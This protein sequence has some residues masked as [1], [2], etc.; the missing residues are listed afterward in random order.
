MKKIV[1]ST[2]MFLSVIAGA[3][4]PIASGSASTYGQ[5][6]WIAVKASTTVSPGI[7]FYP[8][9]RFVLDDDT[10]IAGH[11]SCFPTGLF[12][13]KDCAGYVGVYSDV[14]VPEGRTTKAVE[15]VVAASDPQKLFAAVEGQAFRRLDD[16]TLEILKNKGGILL[17]LPV[18]NNVAVQAGAG[19]PATASESKPEG[20]EKPQ[21]E[22]KPAPR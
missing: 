14:R 19:H 5:K 2:L 6:V 7:S 18:T 13:G 15:I 4:E 1:L 9:M 20:K 16:K 10:L 11:T 8:N 21:P 12:P 17:R 22:S 3:A